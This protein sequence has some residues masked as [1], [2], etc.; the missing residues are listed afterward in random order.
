VSGNGCNRANLVCSALRKK[1]AKSKVL[2]FL[3]TFLK[4][5]L[6]RNYSTSGTAIRQAVSHPRSSFL[7]AYFLF[8][9]KSFFKKQLHFGNCNKTSRITPRSSF[10]FAYFFFFAKEKVSYTPLY[11]LKPPSTGITTPFTKPLACSLRR[12]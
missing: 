11:A 2:F 7:F 6:S 8:F 10:L 3:L 12:N 9:A 1:V 5:N 4:R